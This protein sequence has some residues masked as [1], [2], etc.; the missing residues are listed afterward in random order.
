MRAVFIPTDKRSTYSGGPTFAEYLVHNAAKR[1]AR[2]LGHF[3][4][5]PD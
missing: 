3:G 4:S 2:R 5:S 1:I